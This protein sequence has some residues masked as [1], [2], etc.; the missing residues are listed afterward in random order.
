MLGFI[1][2]FIY[3][4]VHRYETMYIKSKIQLSHKLHSSTNPQLPLFVK[5]TKCVL[6]LI[7]NYIYINNL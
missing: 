7:G 4:K 5:L 1:Q 3:K 6:Y 2:V